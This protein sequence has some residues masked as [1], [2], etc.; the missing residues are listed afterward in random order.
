VKNTI[1][2]VVFDVGGV[3]IKETDKQIYSKISREI[4]ISHN[5][6]EEIIEKNLS[7]IERGYCSILDFWKK[8]CRDLRIKKPSPQKLAKVFLSH[9]QRSAKIQKQVLAITLKLKR[10]YK[11]GIISNTINEHA[12]INKKRGFFK[13]FHVVILSSK[14]GLI[15]PE[16]KIYQLAAKLLRLKPKNIMFIDD[17]S[18]NIGPAKKF[19]FDAVRFTSVK[20]L[21]AALRKRGIS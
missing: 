2:G 9:Y 8:I 14:V 7:P 10:N 15:K 12:A 20:N 19:G 13:Y 6:L 16:R 1:K 18:K 5:K 21:K 4:N 11:L 3:L 17:Q